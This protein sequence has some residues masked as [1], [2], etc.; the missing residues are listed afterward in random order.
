MIRN[1]LFDVLTCGLILASPLHAHTSLDIKKIASKQQ[2][3]D[4]KSFTSTQGNF[5]IVF[6][7]EPQEIDQKIDIPKT[8]LSI[9]YQTYLSE[10]HD[11]V[12]Y[13]VSVWTYPPE[14]DMSRPEV[15]LQDGFGGMLSALP[16]SE[17]ISMEMKDF[18]GFKGLEFLVKSEDIY[19]QGML[20]LANNTLYQV[21]AVYKES[22]KEL[23]DY[24]KFIGSFTF[25]NTQKAIDQG[26]DVQG[27]VKKTGRLQ[28]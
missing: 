16:G 18:Q 23:V 24:Q 6:P 11:N 27:K 26:K 8:E 12:V 3:S 10:P 15:N 7:T 4:W 14:I 22:E 5:S 20:I 2:A 21:F 28:V 13:V 9:Q 25:L 17:V 19:F 1:Y